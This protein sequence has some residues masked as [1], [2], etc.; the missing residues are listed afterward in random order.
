LLTEARV[1]PEAGG[2][3]LYLE[4][5]ANTLVLHLLAKYS[6][7]KLTL[8]NLKGGMPRAKLKRTIDFINSNLERDITLK[9][10]PPKRI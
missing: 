1:E 4:S 9:I 3:P 6:K 5:L 2:N 10:L 8:P 7:S